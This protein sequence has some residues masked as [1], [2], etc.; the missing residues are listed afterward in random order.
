[1][2]LKTHKSPFSN[3]ICERQASGRLKV[4]S[5]IVLT[6]L[7]KPF[8]VG[9]RGTVECLAD[10]HPDYDALDLRR[11]CYRAMRRHFKPFLFSESPFYFEAGVNG[12][13]IKDLEP[14]RGVNSL[15]KKFYKEQSLILDE[16]FRILGARNGEALAL[17]CGPFSDDMHHVSPLRTILAKG[18]GGV[19]ADVAAALGKCPEND[20]HGVAQ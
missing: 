9:P 2:E 4:K 8:V 18:F 15:C 3:S 19:F 1:M 16:E 14:A 20:L 6:E 17:C 13:W 11:E 7:E 5:Q 10:A 12:G